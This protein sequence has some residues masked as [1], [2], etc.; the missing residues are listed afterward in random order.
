M[1]NPPPTTPPSSSAP[2]RSRVF[3]RVGRFDWA[4]VEQSL[5]D[6]GSARLPGLLTPEEC[7]EL[8]GLYPAD[9]SF[10]STVD[11][12]Q[13]RF[14]VGQYRYFASP[15]PALVRT[16]RTALYPRLRQIANRWQ[17]RLAEPARFP[18][19][20][21]GFLA[22][23]AER[24][25]TRPTP[26][27]LRYTANGYNCL[28]QDLYGELAFPLQ[29]ACLLSKPDGQHP[30]P[31]R[32]G[33]DFTGGEFLL[34]EQRP[35]AQSRGEAIVLEQGEGLIF[36]NRSRPVAGARGSYRAQVRHGVSRV[37]AG[38]R[39]TLGIIFHDAE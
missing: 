38:E 6:F 30:G 35:R 13:H 34:T 37:H 12:E 7:D 29:V 5:D 28:H 10:R 16:L 25:Q 8:I 1:A 26:L 31:P 14:G 18:A 22:E 36:P 9:A 15:L 39:F 2:I 33:R 24:G 21:S 23:C 4:D 3:T 19:R 17:E 27:L 32:R 20:L 11:M